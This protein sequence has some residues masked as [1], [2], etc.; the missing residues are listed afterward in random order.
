MYESFQTSWDSDS[1]LAG[2]YPE[3]AVE[4]PNEVFHKQDFQS[5]LADFLLREDEITMDY[6]NSEDGVTYTKLLTNILRGVGRS[7]EV[8]RITKRVHSHAK[9]GLWQRSSLWLLIKIVI[10]TSLDHGGVGCVYYKSFMLHFMCYLTKHSINANLSS[11]LLH[12]ISVKILRR[13][14][15]LSTSS[16]NWLYDMVLKTNASLREILET[17]WKEVEAPCPLPSLWEPS[18][19]DLDG[20]MQLLLLGSLQYIY[21]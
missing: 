11:C 20:D 5:E 9:S 16:P 15:K 14:R 8:P 12:A 7:T 21:S 18:Q 4:I 13:L 3:W 2:S 6:N 17:R 10:Q 1:T 19:L